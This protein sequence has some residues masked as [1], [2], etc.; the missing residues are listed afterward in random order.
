MEEDE[1]L[2][3]DTDE[4]GWERVPERRR[5]ERRLDESEPLKVDTDEFGWAAD[6]AEKSK[7]H[8]IDRANIENDTDLADLSEEFDWEMQH[9]ERRDTIKFNSYLLD[10]LAIQ[11]S[12][13]CCHRLSLR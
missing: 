12:L 8:S 5:T 4:F 1:L 6:L 9:D 11:L 3:I 13:R 7:H 2:R 10:S